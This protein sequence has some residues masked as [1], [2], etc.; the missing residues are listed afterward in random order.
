MIALPE[1]KQ[2][3]DDGWLLM[4]VAVAAAVGIPW[5]LRSSQVDLGPVTWAVF[6]YGAGYLAVSRAIELYVGPRAKVPA[7]VALQVV[8]VVFLASVW[9]LAGNLQNPMFLMAFALPVVATACVLPGAAALLLAALSVV[10]AI[11]VAL[12]NAPQLRWYMSQIGIPVEA[13]PLPL[14]GAQQAFPGLDMPAAY[15]FL[16]LVTFAVCLFAVALLSHSVAALLRDLQAR[17][18]ASAAAITQAHSLAAEVIGAAPHP[19]VL[20]YTDTLNVA[21]ASATFLA[22]MEL[23]PESLPEKNLLGLVDFAYPEV[24]A[25]L[26][27]GEGGEVPLALYRVGGVAHLARVHVSIAHHAGA[28]YA[29]VTLED[30][31]QRVFGQAALDAASPALL[32]IG[33]GERVRAFN[34]AAAKLLPELR[35]GIDAALLFGRDAG[36]DGGWWVLGPRAQRERPVVVAGR[37]CQARCTSVDIGQHERVTVIQLQAARG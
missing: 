25:E 19:T 13:L 22:R 16:M 7:F 36:A 26:V 33:A 28:R 31:H 21:Q 5:F 17:L 23:L 34:P 3:L 15:L 11:A 37:E 2:V 1:R 32:V 35:E 14:Q 24:V 6:L 8:A 10:A 18:D 20:V 27:A 4:L 12:V 30:V 29:C 9:H